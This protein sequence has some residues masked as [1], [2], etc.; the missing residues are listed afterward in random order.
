MGAAH[1]GVPGGQR[2]SGVTR[3]AAGLGGGGGRRMPGGV[4]GRARQARR[5]GQP[6]DPCSAC[7]SSVGPVRPTRRH[8]RRMRPGW[9]WRQVRDPGNLGTIVRTVDA[10]GASGVLLI[11]S[12]V[13]PYAREAVR[14]SMGSVFNVPLVRMEREH[15]VALAEAWPG[16]VVGTELSAQEDFRAGGYRAPALL[17]MGSE[18]PACR[19]R[20]G[21]GLLAP[22]EDPDGR[23][24]RQPQ[25]GGRDRAD[26]LRDAQGPPA[27]VSA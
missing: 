17:V 24:A 22:R 6:A 18:G 27:P 9:R 21:G 19:R 2:D 11:G 20:L 1:A 26:A 13:D 10:V 4:G 25:P 7:S 3:D 23:P 12:S 15:A 16:D 14:A 8:C 5:Q